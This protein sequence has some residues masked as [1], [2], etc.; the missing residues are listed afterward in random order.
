MNITHKDDITNLLFGSHIMEPRELYYRLALSQ[1]NGIGPVRYKKLIAFF[2]TAGNVFGQNLKSLTKCGIL[3]EQNAISI[4]SFSD[5][6]NIET[7]LAYTEKN[8]IKIICFD[9][10]EYPRKLKNCVDSPILLFQKG[11]A[12]LNSTRI[13]SVIGTRSFTEYG[14]RM[15]EELIA[16]LKS[17]NVMI[18][19]GLAYGIDIIAHRSCIKN[20]MSTLGVVAH[21]LDMIY[22]AAHASVAKEMQHNGGLL[23][24][25]FS[26][27]KLEK[28][29]F[30]ARN[31]IVAGIA[32]ATVVVETDLKGGSM[33]TADIA[34]SYNREVFC[35]PGRSV[36]SKSMGC[37]FLIKQLKA[38]LVTCADDI[39]TELGWK[40]V[41]RPKTMQKELFIEMTEEENSL[42]SIL[43][44][45]PS[46]HI[47][48]LHS[49]SNLTNSQMA[50]AM[51]NLEMQDIIHVMPGKMV[52]LKY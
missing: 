34:F 37:N 50:G 5:F 6:K 4:K 14:R 3:S 9:D 31:R 46:I 18:A 33:I 42:L 1:V 39:V 36:D 48:E 12:D 35:F 23:S 2:G 22:P 19:S 16:E 15:C 41:A 43:N 7:E 10:I 28:G 13:L 20:D 11:H 47:D 24:E 21:G 27:A 26:N 17:Y 29:N 52:S 49:L 30:P 8:H 25:Y 40:S 32:D 45:K 51:L 44:Q 38:Q